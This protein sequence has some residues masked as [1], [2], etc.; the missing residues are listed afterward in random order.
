VKL[1]IVFLESQLRDSAYLFDWNFSKMWKINETMKTKFYNFFLQE[2]LIV[3][4]YKKNPAKEKD[5]G[6]I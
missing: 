5:N 2:N 1:Q 6:F 4:K 3:A